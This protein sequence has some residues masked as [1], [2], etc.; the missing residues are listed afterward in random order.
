LFFPE[1]ASAVSDASLLRMRA[2]FAD[3]AFFLLMG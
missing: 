3:C 1:R 2:V